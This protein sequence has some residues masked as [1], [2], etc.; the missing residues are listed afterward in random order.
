MKAVIPTALVASL[1]LAGCCTS[2]DTHE[3]GRIDLQE[4]GDTSVCAIFSGWGTKEE[5]DR[6]GAV[7]TP[8]SVVDYRKILC[9]GV[10]IEDYATCANRVEDYYRESLQTGEQPGDATSGPFAVLLDD[11]LYLGSYRSDVFRAS[12]Q[13]ESDTNS[14]RGA[15]SAFRGD[16]EPVFDIRCEDGMRGQGRMVLDRYGSDGIGMVEM[17]DGTQGRIVFGPRIAEVADAALR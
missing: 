12:F 2:I 5:P 10:D 14:C 17:D 11:T 15:Y 7:Y 6:F 3:V 8:V 1:S 9:S 4:W 13:V 16:K